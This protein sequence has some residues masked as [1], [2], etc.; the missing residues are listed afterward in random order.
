MGLDK[1]PSLRHDCAS[2]QTSRL[3][4]IYISRLLSS[5]GHLSPKLVPL[6]EVATLAS[7]TGQAQLDRPGRPPGAAHRP[8]PARSQP[9]QFPTVSGRPD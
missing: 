4:A 9:G 2:A 6:A 5:R 7:R 3:I 1:P 8:A